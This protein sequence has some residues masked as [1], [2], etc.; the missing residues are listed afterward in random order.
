MAEQG[1]LAIADITGYTAYLNE[2]ELEHAQDSL[3]TLLNL[4]ID[5][6]KPPLNISRLEGDAVI[7]FAID[8]SFLQAQSIVDLIDATY[9]AFKHALELMILNTTCDCNAC[10][11]IPNLDLKFFLHH[12]EFILQDV[13]TYSEL[14]GPDV[15]LVHRLSKNTISDATGLTAYAAYTQGAID[16]LAL[17]GFAESLTPHN[18]SYAD[19][20]EVRV[21]VE[22]MSEVWAREH[23]ARRIAVKPD[24][25]IA[26]IEVHSPFNQVLTWE[27]G[28]RPEYRAILM[29][30]ERQDVSGKSRGRMGNGTVYECVHG[31]RVYPQTVVDWRPFDEYTFESKGYAPGTSSLMTTIFEPEGD[32][33]KV[34]VLF[35]KARGSLVMRALENLGTRMMAP[36]YIKRGAQALREALERDQSERAAVQTAA[37]SVSS[38]G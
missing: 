32:G 2:S 19:V 7:S 18:E 22:D 8:G 34:T 6:T 33:T 29:G 3:S 23:A 15:N 20:G 30:S 5:E 21:Y 4:L 36:R 17:P 1:Y 25:A 13:G 16:A 9:Y 14:V 27:H 38:G 26:V 12:G 24:E 10:R 28:T 37:G 31:S 11:N 35:G